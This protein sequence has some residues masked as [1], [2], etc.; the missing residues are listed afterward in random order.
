MKSLLKLMSE[1]NKFKHI[2]SHFFCAFLLLLF[3]VSK[4]VSSAHGFSHLSG[5][6]SIKAASHD[7]N[8]LE[9][10]IFSH[11]QERSAKIDHCF[12]CSF[13]NSQNQ[14]S[15]SPNLFLALT[16]FILI[17]FSRNFNRV[18]LSYLRSSSLSR[19]P[20]ANS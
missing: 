10:L 15:L 7:Q 11:S 2:A 6:A 18:K 19:A 5:A 16:F 4:F 1:K 12:L 17:F 3:V 20:P 13:S 9:K 14:I 8:F